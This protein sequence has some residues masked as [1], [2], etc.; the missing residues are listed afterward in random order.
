LVSEGLWDTS[1]R[2]IQGG[3]DSPDESIDS[4]QQVR[5]SLDLWRSLRKGGEREE[6]EGN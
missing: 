1:I 3:I 6:K 5:P 4:T 2:G